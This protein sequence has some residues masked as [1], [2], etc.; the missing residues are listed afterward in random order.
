V[1]T[2]KEFHTEA[3]WLPQNVKGAIDRYDPR[4]WKGMWKG[5]IESIQNQ[6][7]IEY[8]RL[9]YVGPF[10]PTNAPLFSRKK[11]DEVQRA[12][13]FFGKHKHSREGRIEVQI[14]RRGTNEWKVIA[15]SLQ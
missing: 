9:I 1:I 13:L 14:G 12:H 11:S 8:R 7:P 10:P 3:R 5:I 15:V 4:T 6:L 2:F